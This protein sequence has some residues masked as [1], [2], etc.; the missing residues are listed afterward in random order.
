[1]P[2]NVVI[3]GVTYPFPINFDEGWGT[4]VTQWAQAV[5]QHLLQKTGGLFTLSAEVDFGATFGLRTAYYKSRATNVAAA[6]AI[7]LGNT[8]VIAFRN[9]AN[10]AD[11]VLGV[12]T[13]NQ[14]TF[15]GNVLLAAAGAFTASR[16]VITDGSGALTTSSVT[17][18]EIGH[19][20]GVTSSIQTQLN[21][22]QATGN[23]ITALTGEVTATGPGSVA[24][25]I[26]NA[27]V[28]GKVLTG[29]VSGAGTVAATDT[30]LQAVQKLNGNTQLLQPV[31]MQA[32]RR[33]STQ[34]INTSATELVMNTVIIDN[35]S[36]HNTTNGR[37]TA[38]ETGWYEVEFSI[39]TSMGATAPTDIEFYV[40][41][42]GTGAKL[43][44]AYTDA[45][46]NSKSYTFYG[47][48]LVQLNVGEYVSPW[49]KTTAQ[50]ATMQ[51]NA[52]DYVAS[53]IVRK[54]S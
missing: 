34:T 5:S 36:G 37:Y 10:S 42:G 4:N 15:E 6:G 11:V 18:T 48:A 50:T 33:T 41:K 40:L 43:G 21:G 32:V 45:L 3:N 1:M 23:Y 35:R 24:A 28:I 7:R 51:S 13:S 20:A 25:T 9:A 29:Y 19:L 49:A 47:I 2:V 22:K 8:D 54:I 38:P 44:Y 14:L 31:Y 12:N 39:L 53:L 30:I 16:A 46:T 17:S 26:T 52:S 27:A